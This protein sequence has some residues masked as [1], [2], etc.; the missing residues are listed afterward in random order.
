MYDSLQKMKMPKNADIIGFTDDVAI[1]GRDSTTTLLE[2]TV[3]DD[4]E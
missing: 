4:L 1:V 2:K 3:N